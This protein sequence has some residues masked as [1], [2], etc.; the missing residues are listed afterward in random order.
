MAAAGLEWESVIY[1][2]AIKPITFYLY[3]E[4]LRMAVA[5]DEARKNMAPEPVNEATRNGIETRG[6]DRPADY[7]SDDHEYAPWGFCDGEDDEDD[8]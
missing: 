7:I 3:P 1:R 2:T 5:E 4:A 6:G 8:E